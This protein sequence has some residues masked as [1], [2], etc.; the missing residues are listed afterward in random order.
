VTRAFAAIGWSWGG[1]WRSPT[2]HMHF[3]ATGS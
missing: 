3:S 1:A 2:D